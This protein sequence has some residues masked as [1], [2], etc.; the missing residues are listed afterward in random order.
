MKKPASKPVSG[1]LVDRTRGL[2]RKPKM[3]VA[4]STYGRS[5]HQIRCGGVRE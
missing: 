1:L 5:I 4:Y 2:R 3:G